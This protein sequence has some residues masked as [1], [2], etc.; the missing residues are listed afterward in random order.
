MK[1]EGRT[2]LVTGAGSGIGKAIALLFAQEGANLMLAG[3]TEK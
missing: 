2:A 1:L 3:P